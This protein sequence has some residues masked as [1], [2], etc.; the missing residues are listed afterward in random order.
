MRAW[1]RTR[2]VVVLLA[3]AVVACR[4]QR[5][6]PTLTTVCEIVALAAPL[7]RIPAAGAEGSVPLPARP[8]RGAAL[9]ALRAVRGWAPAVIV[10]QGVRLISTLVQQREQ[11]GDKTGREGTEG[12]PAPS[13]RARQPAGQTQ[14]T[15]APA[16]IPGCPRN[17]HKFPK[18]LFCCLPLFHPASACPTTWPE[19]CATS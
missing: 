2:N 1:R 14:H 19:C 16:R 9:L 11:Q 7:V 5:A 13:C 4:C 3:K 17:V 10:A 15:A 18:Q 12:A 6:A 8:L